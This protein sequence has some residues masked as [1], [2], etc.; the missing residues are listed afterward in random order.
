MNTNKGKP[1]QPN[2]TQQN[3]SAASQTTQHWHGWIVDK[4]NL[5][6]AQL[7]PKPYRIIGVTEVPCLRWFALLDDWIPLTPRKPAAFHRRWRTVRPAAR[8]SCNGSAQRCCTCFCNLDR[9][10]WKAH[11]RR[12]TCTIILCIHIYI[13]RLYIIII[14]FHIIEI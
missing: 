5:C 14:K 9:Y 6:K 1:S 13:C 7:F 3:Q 10:M 2:K 4:R 11:E 12:D 8:N